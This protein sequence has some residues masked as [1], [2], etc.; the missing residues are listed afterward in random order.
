MLKLWSRLSTQSW[1][2]MERDHLSLLFSDGVVHSSHPESWL[3][4]ELPQLIA[5]QHLHEMK[6][7]VDKMLQTGFCPLEV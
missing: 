3:K 4:T 7:I 1:S 5:T 6:L 2:V